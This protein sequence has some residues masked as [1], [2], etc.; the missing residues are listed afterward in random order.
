MAK[1]ARSGEE[2]AAEGPSAAKEQAEA[3][4]GAPEGP[5]EERRS[6][7]AEAAA[8]AG[9]GAERGLLTLRLGAARFGVWVDEVLEIVETPPVSRLPLSS[10]EV[11]G[12]TS[13][14]GDV[15]PVL[16]LGL[17]LLQSPS[18]RPGRLI[19]VRH[20]G[21]GAMV[22]LLVDGVGTLVAVRDDQVQEPPAAAESE[23]PAEYMTG[24]LPLDDEVVTILH[25][26]HATTPPDPSTETS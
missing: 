25:L 12:V 19:L 1:R 7:L 15:V 18:R 22:A 10:P 16:D 8:V 14:R 24:V 26:G 3:T 17:R 4:T 21:T 2:A 9:E 13:I 6:S 5:P 20:E 23:L 11:A